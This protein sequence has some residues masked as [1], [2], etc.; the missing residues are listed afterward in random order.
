LSSILNHDNTIM[1]IATSVKKHAFFIPYIMI[2]FV[3]LF[4]FIINTL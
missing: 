4:G 1:F 3:F 2:F